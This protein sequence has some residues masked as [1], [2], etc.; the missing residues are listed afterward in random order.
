MEEFL[1]PVSVLSLGR[2][3]GLGD[4][5]AGTLRRW[6][7]ALATGGANHEQ[8]PAKYAVSDETSREVDER[9][10]PV[11]ERLEHEP[12]G[13]LLAAMMRDEDGALR[14][15]PEVLADLKIIL[16][17]GMQEPGHA[18][19]LTLWA[20]LGHPEQAAR[21]AADPGLV[22]AAIEEGMRWMSPV[23]TSTRQVLEPV[24]LG[25]VTLEPGAR[26]AAV[27]ASANRDESRWEDAGVFDVGRAAKAH[28][29]F[30]TGPHF[31][32]GHWLARYEQRIPLRM[33]FER[34]PNLR[35]DPAQPAEITGW[36]F[37]GPS[38][39]PVVWDSP[40]GM[41]GRAPGL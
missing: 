35:L 37:R 17:G 34:L 23:G 8:D 29:A 9:L 11:F 26:V 21:V 18:A 25:D 33:L 38:R 7:F 15:R 40:R 16:L 28:R 13:S 27:L 31:C 39:L 3:L 41:G 2:V 10:A 22:E 12:D 36:E 19:G 6:F 32:V 30:G 1:E 24:R 14:P 4:L 20:L 5:D